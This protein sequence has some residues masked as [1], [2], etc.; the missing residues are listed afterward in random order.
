MSKVK[1]LSV[2]QFKL[3]C[4]SD[5]TF[6]DDQVWVLMQ[7]VVLTSEED[8]R[9]FAAILH[10]YRPNLERRFFPNTPWGKEE[11]LEMWPQAVEELRGLQNHFT[12]T[13]AGITA[14][15]LSMALQLTEIGFKK[16]QKEQKK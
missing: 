11:I 13:N 8:V 14:S 6:T 15:Q 5:D 2:E 3:A 9:E 1:E 10:K 16:L 12:R 4:V 7:S